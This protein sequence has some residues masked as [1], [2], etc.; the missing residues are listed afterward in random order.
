[1]IKLKRK[2]LKKIFFNLIFKLP[3]ITKKI[4]NLRILRE[5]TVSDVKN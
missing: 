1:M 4:K 2:K 5:K 3:K